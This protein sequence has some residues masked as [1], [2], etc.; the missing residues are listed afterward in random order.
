MSSRSRRRTLLPLVQSY[1]QQHLRQVRGCSENT[2]RAYQD[3]LRLFFLFVAKKTRRSVDRLSLDDIRAEIVLSF[4]QHLEST[5]ANS[6]TTRNCR[7]AAVRGLVEHLLRYDLTRAD[8]Y[9]R[10]LAIPSKKARTRPATYLEPEEVRLLLEQPDR[11]TPSGA[12]DHALVLLLYNTGARVSEVLDVRSNDLQLKRPRQVRI[13]G[14]GGKERICPLWAETVAALN[15][16]LR[17]LADVNDPIFRS[18]RGAPLTRDGVAYILNK[19]VLKAMKAG[20]NLR[21]RRI[22]PHVL[23]HS[24]AVALLQAGVDLTVIRDYLGHVSVSTTNRYV[25]TNLKMKRDVLNAFW[26]RAG[27]DR[28]SRRPWRPTSKLLAF[29]TSL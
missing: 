8:Q 14:K 12:R 2:V 28:S 9:Q 7:L 26:K 5:R 18:A 24:C 16:L 4:L 3:G 20:H 11:S 1:F 29:L 21:R 19:H 15:P 23:R 25:T 10:I 27:L 13:R 22:T 6:A 17:L